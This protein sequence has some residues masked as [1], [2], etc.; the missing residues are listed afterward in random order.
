[1]EGGARPEG[2]VSASKSLDSL[3]LCT[4]EGDEEG[5]DG[6]SESLCVCLVAKVWADWWAAC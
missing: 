4:G 1:M 5:E 2:G 3:D 6:S